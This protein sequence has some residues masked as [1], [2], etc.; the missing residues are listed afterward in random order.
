[1]AETAPLEGYGVLITGAAD[2]GPAN[3]RFNSVRP[4]FTTTEIM[5]G[6]PP[7]GEVFGRLSS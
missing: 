5:Q 7:E 4:G 1:M 6:V 3:V 2:E